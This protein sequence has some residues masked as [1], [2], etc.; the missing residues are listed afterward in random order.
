MSSLIRALSWPLITPS[1]I[2]PN[3][4][5]AAIGCDNATCCYQQTNTQEPSPQSSTKL[6]NKTGN[7]AINNKNNNNHGPNRKDSSTTTLLTKK[8]SN[9]TTTTM[10]T[11]SENGNASKRLP[12]S[13]PTFQQLIMT[14]RL[15]C[16]HYYPEGG[17]GVVIVI[18]ACL[19]QTITHGLQ[20]CFGILLLTTARK[21]QAHWTDAS[22]WDTH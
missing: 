18:V 20:L 11:I 4:C 3:C 21:F 1:S 12:T 22:K 9:G 17:W 7:G 10:T 5:Q 19:V 14:R 8:A 13:S 2:A 6:A 15:L 16:R